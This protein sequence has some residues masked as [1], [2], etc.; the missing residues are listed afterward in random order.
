GGM[1]SVPM[2]EAELRRELGDSLDMASVNAPGLCV[3]SGPQAELDALQV[4]L[5]A[6][7]I[8]AQRVPI[9]IAAHSRLLEPILK[10]FGDHLRRLRLAP[11]Q[12][13][14]ISNRTGEVLTAAEAT[15]PE[16]WVYHLRGTVLF[17]EGMQTLSKVPNRVYL[18]VGPGKA[19]SS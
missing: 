19:L 18:E 13:P 5:A 17:A 9:D 10:R 3:V 15:D 1:L 16:Y 2:A 6:R 4:R 7:E 14:I 11:P 12:L 8:E